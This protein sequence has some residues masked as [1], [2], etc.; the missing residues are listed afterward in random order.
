[1]ASSPDA[2]AEV[3]A[4]RLTTTGGSHGEKVMYAMGAEFV[5]VHVHFLT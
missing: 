3:Y 5:E 2:M 4:G 1:M